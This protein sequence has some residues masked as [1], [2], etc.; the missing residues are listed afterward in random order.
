MTTQDD[1]IELIGRISEGNP[2][3]MTVVQKLSQAMPGEDF[4]FI[5]G[6]LEEHKIFGPKLWL[7]Y[8]DYANGN[9]DVMATG[10]LKHSP[11]LLT[12]IRAGGYPDWDWAL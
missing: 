6:A 12:A 9:V 10:I 1:F 3:A 2:G 8:K 4:G 11:E 5:I 7:A